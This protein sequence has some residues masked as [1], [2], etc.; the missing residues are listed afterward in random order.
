MIWNRASAFSANGFVLFLGNSQHIVHS[1]KS[2]PILSSIVFDP[3]YQ[4][5]I[6]WVFPMAGYR[7]IW[8]KEPR[9]ACPVTLALGI[10][11]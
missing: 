1:V 5:P 6:P 4:L 7:R 9:L 10:A 8:R 2:S 11:E 3:D